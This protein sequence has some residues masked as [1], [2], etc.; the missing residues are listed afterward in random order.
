MDQQT[1]ESLLRRLVERVEESER[2]YGEAL[3]ELHTRLDRLSHTTESAREMGSPDE[4]ETLGRLRDQVSGLARR[5]EQAQTTDSLDEFLDL[6]KALSRQD[7]S[8]HSADS[9][10][11]LSTAAWAEAAGLAQTAAEAHSAPMP[12]WPEIDEADL[13]TRLVDMAHRLEDSISAAMPSSEI[14]GLNAR[15][16]EIATRF[17]AALSQTPKLENLQ[18]LE[19]QLSEMGQQLGR[20]EVQIARIGGIETQLLRLIERFDEAPA[21]LDEVASK[22]A[23]E[24]ARLVASAETGKPSAAER[25]DAIH[26]DLVA[27]NDRS[28]ATDDRLADTLAAVHE[29]L[30]QLVQQVERKEPQAPVPAPRPLVAQAKAAIPQAAP[31]APPAAPA[32]PHAAASTS[33][34]RFVPA[35]VYAGGSVEKTP[36]PKTGDEP[37]VGKHRSLR[38][39]LGAAIPDFEEGESPSS[40]GRAKRSQ[41]TE[42]AVDL[43]LAAAAARTKRREGELETTEDFI[44]AARRAAQAAAAQAEERGSS[45]KARLGATA[46]GGL[47]AEPQGRRKRSLLMIT[48]A[49]LLIMS[50]ALL[51]GRLKS[52]PEAEAP[53][54]QTEES[55]PA[56]A[57]SLPPGAPE[58]GAEAPAAPEGPHGTLPVA[59]GATPPARSGE[60]EEIPPAVRVSE[61]PV[62]TALADSPA[63]SQRG[64]SEV[65]KSPRRAEPEAGPTPAPQPVSLKPDDAATALP[66]VTFSVAEPAKLPAPQVAAESAAIPANLPLPP[67]GAGPPAMREAAARGDAKAQFAVGLRYGE[68]QGIAQSWTEAARWFGFAAASGLAPAQYRLAVLYERGLGVVKDAGKARSWYM[69]AAEQG[70]VKA[71]HNLGVAAGDVP[72]GKPDYAKAAKWYAEAAAFGLADSQFNLGILEAHGLGVER[73]LA[74]AYKWFSLAAASG[75]AEAAKQ[76]D[77]VKLQIEPQALAAVE[78]ALKTWKAQ[79]LNQAAN[80]PAAPAPGAAD[81]STNKTLVAR[82]QALLNKLG[83]DVGPPDG[84][85]GAR[86]RDAIK[87]FERRNGVAETGDVTVPLVTKLERLTS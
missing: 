9:L 13:D 12:A 84:A 24:A 22:A 21:N 49:L 35:P 80:E 23:N 51:Y 56:P 63:P 73:N 18:H 83:Y 40:F 11:P 69:R 39:R 14:A 71:M 58:P 66:G 52:K 54:A 41:P 25:L 33:P 68:G 28:R 8:G 85:L 4:A 67:E 78:Q 75:D 5:L 37:E 44:A 48:A 77:L 27:M 29:S 59:P 31:S 50:A 65:A 76:R 70:N 60:S 7:F 34:A 19:R 57:I 64:V 36:A 62:D 17:E 42:E 45:R 82:A 87:S 79:P 53:P 38:S 26:R 55:T 47:G 30:K 16:D 15:M 6:G 46:A 1:V 74:E 20:A 2:R 3:E 81:A 32:A 61:A 86:T 72:G 43:D 10:A